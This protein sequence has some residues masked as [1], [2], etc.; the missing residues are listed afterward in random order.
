MADTSFSWEV[1]SFLPRLITLADAA[2]PRS[3]ES[4]ISH[5]VIVYSPYPEAFRSLNGCKFIFIR[6][7]S[8]SGL[9]VVHRF[10][11]QAIFL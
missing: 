11:V 8:A 3:L 7:I 1:R 4:S 9:Q 10:I 6:Q 2:L 5:L